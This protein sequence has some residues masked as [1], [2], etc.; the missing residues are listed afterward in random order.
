[1]SVSAPAST[2]S[3]AQLLLDYLH[4][5][6]VC[7]LF[8]IP[9]GALIYVMNELKAR[10]KEFN[11]VVCRQ[12]SGAVY[13]AHGYSVVTGGLGVVLTTSGPAAANALTGAINAQTACVPV[14]VI[15]GEVPQKYYG[16]AYLQEGIDARLDIGTVYANAVEY[17]TV[18][19][20]PDNFA[21]LF[22][23]A[24]RKAR[25]IPSRV[26]HV[27][28]PNN[29]AAASVP[30]G[31]IA[32]E[33]T[34]TYRSIPCSTDV[35]AVQQLHE[36][37]AQAKRPLILLGNGCRKAL[38]DPNR[39]AEFEH[40]VENHA[41]PVMTTP[42][43]KGIFKESHD[44]SLRNYGLCGCPWTSAYMGASGALE[45]YDA[46]LV[47]GSNLNELSTTVA[48]KSPYAAGLNPRG[49]FIQVDLD[50]SA[51]GRDFP[52]TQGIVAEAGATIDALCARAP[53]GDPSGGRERREAFIKQI[54]SKPPFSHEEWRASNRAPSNPAALMREICRAVDDGHIFIDC[55]NCVGW[56]LHYM[57]ID[58][59]LQFHTALAMGPMG[60]AVGAVIGA[61]LGAPQKACI[62]VCG[63]G[64]F[65]MHGAEI[66]TAAQCG[67]G[68]IW[69]VLNDDDYAM[70]SQGME[71][72]FD[73]PSWRGY[74]RLGSP[75]LAKFAEGLGAHAVT[76]PASSGPHEFRAWLETALRDSQHGKP[77]VIVVQIDKDVAPPFGW[78]KLTQ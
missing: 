55:G 20:S 78:P 71:S 19:S 35:A 57:E 2:R 50:Q 13:I 61:K 26:A 40:F 23:Q 25:S 33:T 58:P 64:A 12:E 51:I 59:P 72:L 49:P 52:I 60:F 15:T 74:Y 39:A 16:R 37:L 8:G 17:S 11:F 63:D 10:D 66:S 6:G 34:Q 7:T 5:E 56:A 32:P 45:P 38:L 70:V 14:L 1:M 28:L 69:I 27:S 31:A 46:L 43:A 68:A 75:D 18:V 9:G 22:Q 42:D 30:P 29:I 48:E 76:V 36:A 47:V 62:A 24:L 53:I 21:T 4:L 44:L 41:I 54:K 77:Q 73:S 3:V 65:M 67:A